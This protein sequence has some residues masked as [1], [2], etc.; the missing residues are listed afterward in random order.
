MLKITLKEGQSI[1]ITS[2]LHYMHNNIVRGVTNWRD[3]E[4]NVP[5]EQVRDFDTLEDMNLSLINN[6]NDNVQEN[7]ILFCLGDWSFGGEHNIENFRTQIN[8]KNIYLVL[9]NHDHHI[10]RKE[11]YRKL[12]TGVYNY[13]ELEIGNNKFIL[14]HYPIA[15]WNGVRKGYIHLCGHTHL[16]NDKKILYGKSMD[17]GVD[18]HPEFRPYKLSE[19]M[20]IMNK[21]TIDSW[22]K[23]KFPGKID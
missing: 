8:C 23:F 2:D 14:S 17:V 10:E 12:F 21:Q 1:W 22:M 6:I 18:G 7:D 9:G 5:I 19:I 16:S 4:G 11:Q 15:S 13:L 3:S 20:E